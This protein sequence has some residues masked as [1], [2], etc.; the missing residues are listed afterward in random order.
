MI[1]NKKSIKILGNSENCRKFNAR[2]RTTMHP[3]N[4]SNSNVTTWTRLPWKCQWPFIHSRKLILS[5]ILTFLFSPLYFR[6]LRQPHNQKSNLYNTLWWLSSSK[7]NQAKG[8]ANRAGRFPGSTCSYFMTSMQH[9][10][11]MHILAILLRFPLFPPFTQQYIHQSPSFS[12]PWSV[13]FLLLLTIP[14]E[15]FPA[16]TSWNTPKLLFLSSTYLH[17]LPL[18]FYTHGYDFSQGM[19]SSSFIIL[20]IHL[21]IYLSIHILVHSLFIFHSFSLIPFPLCL[22]ARILPPYVNSPFFNAVYILLL[23]SYGQLKYK[24]IDNMHTMI[25]EK[26]QFMG[27]STNRIIHISRTF[28]V[29]MISTHIH[30]ETENSLQ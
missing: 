29:H 20:S 28:W 27:G 26:T 7:A 3:W 21:S 18:Y 24:D 12:P 30:H 14:F 5:W 25:M 22:W 23:L 17:L 16:F 9:G 19:L 8:K 6:W 4:I 1:T 10:W 11:C 13:P 2:E 15:N